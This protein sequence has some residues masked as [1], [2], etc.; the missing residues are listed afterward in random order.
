MA[1]DVTG[2][3]KSLLSSQAR[4]QAPWIKVTIGN[5]TFGVFSKTRARQKDDNNFYS[6]YNIQYPNYV[7]S[8]TI[9]KINGQVNTYTLTISY[10]VRSGDDPNFFEKVFSSV[11]S[12]RKIVFSYGDSSMPSYCYKDEEAVITAVNTS[13][14]M[15]GSSASPTLSYTVT[16]I[17]G[18]TLGKTGSFT[19]MNSGK[20]K[21]SDEIKRVFRNSRYGLRALFTGMSEKN[22]DKLIAADDKAVQ[23]DCKTNISP[24]DYIS[25]L[26]GC[27]VPAG[28][29]ENSTNKDIYIL[30]IHDDTTYDKLYEGYDESFASK[31]DINGPY[32][33]IERSTY[34]VE[35]SDAYTIDIGVNTSTIVTNFSVKN[36]NYSMYYD[37]AGDLYPDEYVRRINSK[38]EWEDVYAPTFISNNSQRKARAQDASW[39]TK[40]TKYP[41]SAS[42]TIQGLLRPATLM[43][44]VRLNVYFPGGGKHISSGLYIV[45]AQ[46]DSISE[47]GYR[48]T[49][50][51]TRIDGSTLD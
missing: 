25:Y 38:G 16:A 14:G 21:P 4:V 10:P 45:T 44:Y 47:S 3:S 32:F 7:K 41:I 29:N 27:M 37:Y 8:L 31:N 9:K 48:T 20:K 36:D 26:A 2:K 40:L 34:N 43:Q 18:A 19:F 24:L 5:Y 35:H 23:L 11:S 46:T 30:T 42:I 50:D 1:V 51:L 33:K 28:S 15:S 49:L 13:F 17:S 22:L 39:F 6:A 12:T